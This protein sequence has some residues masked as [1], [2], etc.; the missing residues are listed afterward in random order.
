MPPASQDDELLSPN[1]MNNDLKYRARHGG[2]DDLTYVVV[3]ER[4]DHIL[5]QEFDSDNDGTITVE[6][7]ADY[8]LS[9]DPNE[10]PPGFQDINPFQKEKLRKQLKA[11][12]TDGD[13]KLSFEEFEVWWHETLR[14]EATL[15]HMAEKSPSEIAF[16]AFDIDHDGTVTIDEVLSFLQSVRPHER[17]DGLQNVQS[18]F[19]REKIRRRLQAMDSDKDGCLS[20]SEFQSWWSATHRLARHF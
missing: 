9:K 17:P 11:I 15:N 6:E 8:L 2:R 19:Q 7:V 3:D 14:S 5:F 1:Q 10:R 4:K 16:E 12:D 20:F 13:G 18:S